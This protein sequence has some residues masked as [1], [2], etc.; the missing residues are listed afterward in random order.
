MLKAYCN[1][2]VILKTRHYVHH[3]GI[4]WE[5]DVFGG[6]NE[7]LILA[8]VELESP[9]QVI[10]L[11]DWTTKEVSDDPRYFNALLARFPYKSWSYCPPE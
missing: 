8:E 6:E 10:D 7:G 3:K 4:L 2:G 9:T 1:A 5:V 11:P